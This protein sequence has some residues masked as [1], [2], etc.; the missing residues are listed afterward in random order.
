[1]FLIFF[2]LMKPIL[3]REFEMIKNNYGLGKSNQNARNSL[4]TA[5]Q[6]RGLFT[7]FEESIPFS[8]DVSNNQVDKEK[9]R[10]FYVFT[11]AA[12]TRLDN[13]RIMK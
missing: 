2:H 5:A 10:A 7:S 4:A 6:K 11:F 3:F 8:H 12:K 13:N 9:R 1:M